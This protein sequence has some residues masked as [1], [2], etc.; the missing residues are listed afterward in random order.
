MKLFT[1]GLCATI[2]GFIA[3]P[4]TAQEEERS[5]S[6]ASR[7]RLEFA[8]PQSPAFNLLG[9]EPSNILRP[10][11]INELAVAVS[12]LTGDGLAIPRSFA[13]EFAP[14]LLIG[15]RNL[16]IDRYQ[17][18]A[19]LYRTR[20][21]LATRRSD[22]ASPASSVGWGIRTALIDRG[23]L[24]GSEVAGQLL[25]SLDLRRLEAVRDSIRTAAGI[26]RDAVHPIARAADRLANIIVN[27]S[28]GVRDGVIDTL[29]ASLPEAD[30]RARLRSFLENLESPGFDALV[31]KRIREHEERNWNAGILEVAYAGRAEA[32]D[33][34][35]TGLA[36]QEHAFWA[37]GG[38]RAGSWG[39]LLIGTQVGAVRDSLSGD[40]EAKAALGSRLYMGGN[41]TKAFVEVEG[42]FQDSQRPV[43]LLNS[44]AEV[45]PPFGGWVTF[46]LGVERN[47]L[48]RDSD[49]RT[50][51]AYGLPVGLFGGS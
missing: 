18:R 20:I 41:R 36:V 50:D 13:A 25:D 7:F 3:L 29:V 44:G 15:G 12:N 30:D 49:L 47:R 42:E 31:R 38:L 10:G 27:D 21:S 34:T 37:T 32:A 19:A 5:D 2:C 51:F 39:Q 35:G 24:R 6:L 14:A 28:M 1:L 43:F 40:F 48:T 17:A 9:T 16:T 8:V 11:D 33:S 23:D 26:L 45:R 22:D 4:V 46:S